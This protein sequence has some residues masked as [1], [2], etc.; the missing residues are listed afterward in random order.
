MEK[1]TSLRGFRDI[2]GEEAEK[3]VRIEMVSRAIFEVA[4]FR[5]DQHPHT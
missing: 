4:G 2:S 3:F 1:I 5:E